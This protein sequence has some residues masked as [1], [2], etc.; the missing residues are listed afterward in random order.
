MHV[1]K[2]SKINGLNK[3]SGTFCSSDKN[4]VVLLRCAQSPKLDPCYLA[5]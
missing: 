3:V 4:S 1:V 2:F 5:S